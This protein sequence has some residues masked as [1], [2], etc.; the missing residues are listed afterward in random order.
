MSCPGCSFAT[1]R[2]WQVCLERLTLWKSGFKWVHGRSV[3]K[4]S[5]YLYYRRFKQHF[6]QIFPQI[7]FFNK[8]LLYDEKHFW[9]PEQWLDTT[10]IEATT[11][12]TWKQKW[13]KT[14]QT[15]IWVTTKYKQTD[16]HTYFHTLINEW[17][18]ERGK[19]KKREKEKT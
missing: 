4:G 1:L 15:C 5:V 7:Y 14:K 2:S 13:G 10:D 9:Y 17:L 19:D 12:N 8:Q 16:M 3:T 6:T 18:T 11:W